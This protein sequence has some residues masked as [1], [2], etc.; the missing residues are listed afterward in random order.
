[1]ALVLNEEQTMLQESARSFLRSKA[2]VG[3][4]RGLRDSGAD[5]SFSRELWSEMSALGWPAIAIPESHGGLGFGYTGLG[6]ILQEAGRTLAP[7]PLLAS[8]MMAQSRRFIQPG[9]WSSPPVIWPRR[10]R[11]S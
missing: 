8:S 11:M 1:M 4:L 7:Q 3:H 10:K 2:P 9:C 6:I 5:K